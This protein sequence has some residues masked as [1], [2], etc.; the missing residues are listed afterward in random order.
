MK[1]TSIALMIALFAIGCGGAQPAKPNTPAPSLP[2]PARM[3]EHMMN[4]G[5]PKAHGDGAAT[6]DK[7]ATDEK[8]AE[9]K[10]TDE[11]PAEEKKPE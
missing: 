1:K 3:K 6:D 10:A 5:A 4:S 9:D 7:K 8:P 11:K 2:D